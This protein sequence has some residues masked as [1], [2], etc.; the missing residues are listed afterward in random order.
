MRKNNQ[1]W[2]INTTSIKYWT[3]KV[4]L[5][6]LLLWR[7]YSYK[8]M[9][10]FKTWSCNI[11]SKQCLQPS[12]LSTQYLSWKIDETSRKNLYLEYRG[13]W[14]RIYGCIGSN[15]SFTCRRNRKNIMLESTKVFIQCHL[16]TPYL[17]C[18]I[19]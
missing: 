14:W 5:F 15:I 18:K 2:N 10:Y 3:K 6:Y 17:L 7:D 12:N 11:I 9:H 16:Q 13:K 19:C 1:T 8:Y 4:G